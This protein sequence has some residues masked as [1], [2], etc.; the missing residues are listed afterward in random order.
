MCILGSR[1]TGNLWKSFSVKKYT[2]CHCTSGGQSSRTTVPP[3]RKKCKTKNTEAVVIA[4]SIKYSYF[5]KVAINS[6]ST[7]SC[8]LEKS[9]SAESQVIVVRKTLRRVRLSSPPSL[10][11]SNLVIFLLCIWTCCE[12]IKALTCTNRTLCYNKYT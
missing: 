9:H 11:T 10:R 2:S 8:G 4:T 6:E 12:Q 3:T 1:S 7:S 5:M